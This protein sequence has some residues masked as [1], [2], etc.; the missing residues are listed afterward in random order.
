[1]KN[2]PVPPEIIFSYSFH[3]I[4]LIIIIKKTERCYSSCTIAYTYVPNV[5]FS[6]LD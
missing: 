4:Q 1:M 5:L 2:K 6:I 3:I